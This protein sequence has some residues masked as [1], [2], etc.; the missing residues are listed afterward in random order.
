[1][2]KFKN[3]IVLLMFVT[4]WGCSTANDQTVVLDAAGKHSDGWVVAASGGK[5]PAMFLSAPDTCKE[6]HGTDYKGGV[7]AVSCFSSDRNGISCHP[8]GPSGHPAGWKLPTA[9]GVH[10]K[11]AAV[12]ADG[13]A[14]CAHCHGADYRGAGAPQKDCLRCHT[15]APHPD[16]PWF[17]GTFTHKNTDT[18]NAPVCATCHTGRANLSAAGVTKLPVTAII[19]TSGCFNNTLCH[20]VMGHSSDPQPWGSAANHGARAAA[21]PSSGGNNGLIACQ[22]CHGTNFS[23]GSSNK[24]CFVCHGVNAPHPQRTDWTLQSGTLSHVKAGE[25]NATVCATCHN[26][27]TKN[28]SEPYLTRFASSP[29][30]SFSG[31]APGCYTAAMCHGDVKKTGNC[32]ACHST[33]TTNP[34]KSMAGNTATSDVKVGAHVKHLN[35][36]TQVSVYSANIACSECHTVPAAPGIS[37]AHRN[38]TNDI[39]FGTLAKTGSLAPAYTAAT[40]VCAN[41]YCHGNTLTGGGSNKSPV[42]SQANYLVAGCATCHGYPPTTVR[43]GAAAHSTSSACSGCHAHVNATNN[44][45]VD[46]TK[47]INGVVDA[48]G[49]GHAYPNPGATH[50]AGAPGSCQGCHDITSASGIYPVSR[51][52]APICAGCHIRSRFVGCSDCHGDATTGRPNGGAGTVFPNRQGKHFAGDHPGYT[53]TMC[54]PITSGSQAHG[55][56]NG[57]KS[58][59]AQVGGAG[60]S[61][62][63]WNSTTKSCTPVCHGSA[64]W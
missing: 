35:A 37:G 51:G 25:G 10:A 11:A 55:W 62:S 27:G 26:L 47:H 5:H 40:G 41:T 50:R 46:A 21:D 31:T 9:H 15:A 2:T 29:A 64:T 12:G 58:T 38:G 42:W 22:Q 8:Q 56:S 44:G 17:G 4:L 14:F 60:T 32:D 23:G 13:M 45:F 48:S 57:V 39:N 6:C 54:H 24:S 20:G 49:G 43:N 53:C 18:S 59:A 16:K 30:G 61:I 19:G 52:T 3:A 1:M 33:A 7:T 28:L 36:A 63:S 34:F